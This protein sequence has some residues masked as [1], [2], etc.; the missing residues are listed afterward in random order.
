MQ[1]GSGDGRQ[2]GDLSSPSIVTSLTSQ[3]LIIAR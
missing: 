1:G 3:V 2:P